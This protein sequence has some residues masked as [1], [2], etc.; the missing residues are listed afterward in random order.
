MNTR[1]TFI[2]LAVVLASLT[3]LPI[4]PADEYNQASKITFNQ[5]VR[6]PGR[7]L[8]AGTYWFVLADSITNRNTVQIF[9]SDRSTLYATV[10]TITTER[11]KPT[12]HSAITFAE[13]TVMPTNAIVNW[14]YPGLNSG[15]EFAYP[16]S[17]ERELARVTHTTVVAM[18]PAKHQTSAALTPTKHQPPVGGD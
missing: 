9:N 18:T 3:V 11:L 13:Q 1:K 10:Q 17:E 16:G 15:H 2:T 7:V 14:F 5:S 12:D 4:A 8:P 6:I